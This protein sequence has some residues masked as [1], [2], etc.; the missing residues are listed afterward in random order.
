MENQEEKKIEEQQGTYNRKKGGI[1][2]LAIIIAVLL[3]A[4]III[5]FSQKIPVVKDVVPFKV[6]IDTI[7]SGIKKETEEVPTYQSIPNGTYYDRISKRAT[8]E[9]KFSDGIYHFEV[10]WG[11]SAKENTKW[12]FSGKFDKFNSLV[13]YTDSRCVNEVYEDDGTKSE[14]EVYTDGRG[15]IKV[16]DG[17][18]YW[19]DDNDTPEY[20]ENYNGIFEKPIENNV[21]GFTNTYNINNYYYAPQQGYNQG[22]M[23]QQQQTNTFFILNYDREATRFSNGAPMITRYPIIGG[24]N[25]YYVNAANNLIPSAYNSIAKWV[26]SNSIMNSFSDFFLNYASIETYTFNTLYM[27]V[28]CALKKNGVLTN[29]LTFRL[30]LYLDQN[31]YEWQKITDSDSRRVH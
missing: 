20:D 1:K 12:V 6:D 15:V 3:F 9:V 16:T 19:V 30:T 27:T 11:S 24:N 26:G 29:H 18:L 28:N 31:R 10:N 25:Q 2:P 5:L 7:I 22:Y 21:E 23:P 8:M 4:V 13:H 14:T 17:V